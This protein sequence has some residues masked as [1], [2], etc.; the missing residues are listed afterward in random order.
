MENP[1]KYNF[2]PIGS[3]WIAIPKGKYTFA[4]ATSKT[5]KFAIGALKVA[6]ARIIKRIK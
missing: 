6:D 3:L 4:V 5:L 1:D 2:V